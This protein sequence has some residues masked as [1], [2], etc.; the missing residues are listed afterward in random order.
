MSAMTRSIQSLT[1]IVGS[2]IATFVM[3]VS[4]STTSAAA[5]G[6]NSSASAAA[7][8]SGGTATTVCRDYEHWRTIVGM[9]LFTIG[10]A[11]VNEKSKEPD[12]KKRR[13]WCLSGAVVAAAGPIIFVTTGIEGMH[14]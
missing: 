7:G 3:L 9:A 5:S 10:L 12:E 1:C 4:A 8:S 14:W 11:L 2:A 13:A 6:S